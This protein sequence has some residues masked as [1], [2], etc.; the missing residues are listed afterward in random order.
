MVDQFLHHGVDKD[1][2]TYLG[3]DDE[4]F[5][6]L[7]SKW[8]KTRLDILKKVKTHVNLELLKNAANSLTP[9]DEDDQ[10]DPNVLTQIKNEQETLED[11][12]DRK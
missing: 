7:K 4:S 11:F 12:L 8:T 10:N 9:A 6:K 1:Y 2:Q 3:L 5:N